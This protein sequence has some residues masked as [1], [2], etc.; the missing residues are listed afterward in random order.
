MNPSERR[1]LL[2]RILDAHD[3]TMRKLADKILHM[4]QNPTDYPTSHH[5]LLERYSLLEEISHNWREEANRIV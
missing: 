3:K 4:A 5:M 1:I 2:S